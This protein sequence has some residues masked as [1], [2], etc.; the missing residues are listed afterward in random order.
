MNIQDTIVFINKEKDKKLTHKNLGINKYFIPNGK[1]SIDFEYMEGDLYTLKDG[2]ESIRKNRRV[3]IDRGLGDNPY[4]N[5]KPFKE[6]LKKKKI[7][8][9][10]LNGMVLYLNLNKFKLFAADSQGDRGGIFIEHCSGRYFIRI[11][12]I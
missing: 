7:R 5:W 4:D 12:V 1:I 3:L 9:E 11:G 10:H 8:N 2:K 6:K